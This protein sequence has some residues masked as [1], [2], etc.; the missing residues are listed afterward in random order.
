M[1]DP[2]FPAYYVSEVMIKMIMGPKGK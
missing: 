2:E 1:G